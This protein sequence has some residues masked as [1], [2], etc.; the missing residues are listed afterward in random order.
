M[1]VDGR[2]DFAD[3]DQV[4]SVTVAGEDRAVIIASTGIVSVEIKKLKT[5]GLFKSNLSD[6]GARGLMELKELEKLY[7]WK[8]GISDEGFK[9]VKDLNNLKTVYIEGTKITDKGL[10]YLS[11]KPK[12]RLPTTT[13]FTAPTPWLK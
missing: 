12:L 4:V 5:L 1:H 7:V 13:A 2:L 6:K 9:Y 11:G 3:G 8:T 10:S